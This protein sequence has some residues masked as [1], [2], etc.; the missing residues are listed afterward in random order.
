MPLG[1]EEMLNRKRLFDK[2]ARENTT[3]TPILCH[4]GNNGKV[5]ELMGD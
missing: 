4:C 5:S 2:S 1:F 3:L